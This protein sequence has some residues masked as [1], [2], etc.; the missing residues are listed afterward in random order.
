MRLVPK[1]PAAA[2]A[3]LNG[4]TPVEVRGNGVVLLSD[5]LVVWPDSDTSRDPWGLRRH[6]GD[7]EFG[8]DELMGVR[9]GGSLLLAWLR[10]SVEAPSDRPIMTWREAAVVLNKDEDTLRRHRKRYNDEMVEANFENA[11]AVWAWWTDLHRPPNKAPSSAAPRR[12]RQKESEGKPL[13]VDELIKK[14]GR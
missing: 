12:V 4:S 9:L 8:V 3:Q 11:D 5:G 14:N 1:P 13:N 7:E 10:S 2:L 6:P